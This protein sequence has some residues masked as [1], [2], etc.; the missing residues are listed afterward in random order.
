MGMEH[1]WGIRRPIDLDVMVDCHSRGALRGRIRNISSGGLF[2]AT[3]A[4]SPPVHAGVNLAFTLRTNGLIRISR[5]EAVVTRVAE[6]G[7][8]LMFSQFNPRALAAVLTSQ[9]N[10]AEHAYH[11]NAA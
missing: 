8:G 4:A 7:F 6:D 10:A 2:V 11:A 3:G 1:R 9:Q 5:I